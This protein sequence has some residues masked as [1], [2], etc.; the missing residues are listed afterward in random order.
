MRFYNLKNNT[1]WILVLGSFTLVTLIL[2]N[3]NL[4]F[5]T[6]KKEERKKM[7]LWATAQNDLLKTTNLNQNLGKLYAEVITSNTSTPMILVN[8]NGKIESFKNIDK[9]KAVARD[10]AYLKRLLGRIKTENKP[11][12]INY[13]TIHQ[14]LYYGDSSLLKKIRYYPMA[15]LLI[16]VL[17][18]AVIYFFFKTSKISEQNKLW[19]GMA[20]E[21]AHQIG[22]P[23]TSLYGWLTLLKSEP[24]QNEALNEIEKDINRLKIITERFSKIG[25]VPKLVPTEIVSE[26]QKAFEYLKARS[27]KLIDFNLKTLKEQVIFVQLN[28][29]LYSWTIE[30]LV[31]NAIDAT[32]GK[33]EVTIQVK[34]LQKMVSICITDTGAGIDKSKFKKI[35]E[36]GYTTK[37]RGWG[38]GLSLA[39]RIIE[40]YH[41]G[42]IRV[43][44][45]VLEKGSTIEILL[46]PSNSV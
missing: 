2:W 3:T 1:R 15:L 36:P 22:T 33:G 45:S 14:K 26:T 20:K 11:F 43:K 30:N 34:N 29:Q 19:A 4:L 10:S 31:K 5:Q 37:K 28:P 44:N 24:I 40:N 23:L 38:L 16:I 6:M 39:K 18:G 13:K 35:F 21:T 42:K 41:K 25:S 12:V 32:K 9:T 27:S 7:Q 17:F 8:E 46:K